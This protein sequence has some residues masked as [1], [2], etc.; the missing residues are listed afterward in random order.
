MEN[1][2]DIVRQELRKNSDEKTR[3]SQQKFFKEKVKFYGV[4]NP[5]VHKICQEFSGQVRAMNKQ[6]VFCLWIRTIWFRKGMDGC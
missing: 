5:V 1:I 4:K 6:E 2:I 3:E